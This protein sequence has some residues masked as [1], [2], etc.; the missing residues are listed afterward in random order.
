[1]A[2]VTGRWLA[3]GSLSA[4]A[5][6]LGAWFALRALA[7]PVLRVEPS[8]VDFGVLPT[9]AKATRVV[10]VSNTGSGVLRIDAVKT[11]CGCT[12]V[13]LV[14]QVLAPGWSADLVV[15]QQAEPT[16]GQ[17]TSFVYLFSNDLARPVV[18]IPVKYASIMESSLDPSIIDFGRVRQGQLPCTQVARF[19]G[20]KSPR[21]LPSPG[22]LRAQ[23]DD[24]WL[25]V[26][27]SA[28]RHDGVQ[29]IRVAL[30]KDAPIG[31]LFSRLRL[32]RDDSDAELAIDV[33]GYVRGAFFALPQMIVVGP[34]T[35]PSRAASEWISVR[36]R[37]EVPG[38]RVFI[39]PI[40]VG[41]SLR[42][43]LTAHAVQNHNEWRV[44]VDIHPAAFP[45]VWSTCE[46]RGY[47][48]IDCR[49][50]RTA[51]HRLRVPV[52][53]RIAAG[54]VGTHMEGPE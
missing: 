3:L 53:L 27:V 2:C 37:E 41:E 19:F 24:P 11:G 16:R 40:S 17:T 44:R 49:T 50:E 35:D 42:G 54:K 29:E 14:N 26:E 25:S 18:M 32:F 5:I 31:E 4:V 22:L 21:G 1:M 48:E 39:G 30:P 47:V 6:S 33:C 13:R 23:S 36:K 38:D 10:H 9:G 52:L 20:G 34:L 8:A 43:Y 12:E 7:S 46:V 15:M 28:P 45:Q 51:V